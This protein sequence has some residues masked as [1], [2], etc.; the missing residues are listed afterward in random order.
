MTTKTRSKRRRWEPTPEEAAEL[1]AR[2]QAAREHGDRV[3]ST[4]E[5][6]AKLIDRLLV[7]GLGPNLLSYTLRNQAMLLG[8]AEER[9]IPLSEV[10]GKVGWADRGRKI[11]GPGLRITAPTGK[12]DR[13]EPVTDSGF[14]GAGLSAPPVVDLTLNTT[15]EQ[16]GDRTA[17]KRT[18][19]VLTSVWDKSQTEPKDDQ[20]GEGE[21]EP[22]VN[23]VKAA[24]ILV[25]R[26]AEQVAQAGYTV[27]VDAPD[28]APRVSNIDHDEQTIAVD[29]SWS[30]RDKALGLALGLAQIMRQ[31]AED[32]AGKAAAS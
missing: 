2:N 22:S 12:R 20:A 14:G 15:R 5:G 13:R 28:A 26:L 30:P 32:R 1:E 24:Q 25:Q 18:G 29:S 17:P 6:V 19:F 21:P 8:Q 23:A 7:S 4:P 9:G 16:G 27:V 31:Q 11:R 10:H 3:L